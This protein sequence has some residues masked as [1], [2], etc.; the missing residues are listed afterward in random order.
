MIFEYLGDLN[1]GETFVIDPETM[2]ITVDGDPVYGKFDGDFP[3]ILPGDTSIAY[4]DSETSRNVELSI[5]K[6]DRHG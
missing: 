3:D 5:V 1:P 6:E 2:E 4:T